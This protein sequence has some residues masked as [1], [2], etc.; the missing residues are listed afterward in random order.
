M[1]VTKALKLD[2]VG[3]L[4]N[5][6]DDS[7]PEVHLQRLTAIDQQNKKRKQPTHSTEG[8]AAI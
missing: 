3:V 1:S 8:N 6:G 7:M 5:H 2:I 4:P